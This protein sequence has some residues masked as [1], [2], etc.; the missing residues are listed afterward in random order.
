MQCI[1]YTGKGEGDL[2]IS[3]QDLS[4]INVALTTQLLPTRLDGWGHVVSEE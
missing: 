1:L 4:V 3:E 2:G